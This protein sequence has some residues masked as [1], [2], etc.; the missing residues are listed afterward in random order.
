MIRFAPAASLGPTMCDFEPEDTA[1]VWRETSRRA[2]G[3]H[4]CSACGGTIQ[5]GDRYVEFFS[6]FEGDAAVAKACLACSGA[7]GDFAAAH[8]GWRPWPSELHRILEDCIADGD[9]DSDRWRPVLE[10][11]RARRLPAPTGEEKA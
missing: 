5:P 7:L 8:D 4:C 3:A 6:V 2:R 9:E 10:A 11:L 1:E